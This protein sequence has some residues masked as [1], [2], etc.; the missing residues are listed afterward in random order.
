MGSFLCFIS[1]QISTN[2]YK[3]L[4]IPTYLYIPESTDSIFATINLKGQE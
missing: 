4:P 1:L 3:S 2:F